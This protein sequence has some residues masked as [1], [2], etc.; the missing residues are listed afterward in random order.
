M[1]DAEDEEDETLTLR[2]SSATNATLAPGST[3]ATG[4]IA[5]DD[6]ASTLTVSDASAT[7]GDSVNFRVSLSPASGQQVIG[8][9]RNCERHGR[10]RY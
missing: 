2:L 7:E 6:G 3:T 8:P 10:E 1:D 9:I 4:T 5:D